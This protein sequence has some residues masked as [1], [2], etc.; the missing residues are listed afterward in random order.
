MS[1]ILFAKFSAL[2]LSGLSCLIWLY[3][4]GF[5]GKFW[6]TNQ[7]ITLGP[8][9]LEKYPNIT[10]IIPARNES[11]AL[12]ISLPSILEQNYGGRVEVVI[13]DDQSDDGTGEI[14][15]GMRTN[16]QTQG[17]LTVISGEPLPQ[18]WSGK[19]WAIAQG[20]SYAEKQE[21]LPD[22]YLLTD[23]DIK[24]D[25]HNLRNLVFK[26]EKEH[27]GSVSL[28]VLLRCQ[29]FWERFLIPAFVFFFAKLYPF[30]LVNTPESKVAAAAGG[31]ILIRRDVLKKIGGIG[32]VKDALIDD[33]S[34][35]QVV[36]SEGESIWLGLTET[37]VSLRPYP[38]L[39]TI[40]DMVARTAFTQLNYSLWMLLGAVG[41][42]TVVYLIPIISLIWGII[43]GEKSLVILGLTTW[44]LM[45]TAY[46][47]T[48]RFY[49]CSPVWA[50]CL[51]AIAFFYTLMTIDSAL[52]HWQGQGGAWKGRVYP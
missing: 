29:S 47:P 42:M 22:Y 43:G 45:A 32:R 20:I 23:A 30:P 5:R 15:K 8:D 40:W 21:I 27:L 11:E 41:G 34:L 48:V 26:A 39:K 38:T 14:A 28:M 10:V 33:C 51:P 25:R 3:L 17:K 4:L 50:F 37:T 46:L 16:C 35:A 13:V 18:G 12:P 52:R 31:C 24:H 9:N 36:K 7:T 44:L 1:A 19:L 6:L 2:L 49:R